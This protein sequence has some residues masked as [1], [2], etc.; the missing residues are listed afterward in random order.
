MARKISIGWFKQKSGKYALKGITIFE[1]DHAYDC[2]STFRDEDAKWLTRVLGADAD[3]ELSSNKAGE[4]TPEGFPE[5]ALK[6]GQENNT[7]LI[8]P[9]DLERASA[10]ILRHF[11]SQIV[12]AHNSKGSN[13]SLQPL[14]EE[15]NAAL[16]ATDA[17]TYYTLLEA[18]TILQKRDQKPGRAASKR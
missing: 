1:D 17:G 12:E 11:L 16:L 2:M 6:T 5:W 3:V 9:L 15:A 7:S 13:G 18:N 14:L 10:T 8:P 4:R